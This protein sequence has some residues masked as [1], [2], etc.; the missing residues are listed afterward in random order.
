MLEGGT[1]TI[2]N[3]EYMSIIHDAEEKGVHTPGDLYKNK[4]GKC[5]M[6]KFVL[7]FALAVLFSVIVFAFIVRR[8]APPL[9]PLSQEETP[10]VTKVE[11]N[12]KITDL[13]RIIHPTSTMPFHHVPTR[14]PPPPPKLLNDN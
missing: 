6:C 4:E 13:E 3:K 14:T 7:I 5:T 2:Y 10:L 1:C 8:A 9:E 12:A 11:M